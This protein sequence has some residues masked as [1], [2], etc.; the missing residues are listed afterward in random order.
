MFPGLTPADYYE[1]GKMCMHDDEPKNSETQML[2]AVMKWCRD[3][4]NIR[5]LYTLADGIMGKCGYVYQAFNFKYG[6]SFKT[7]IYMSDKG[8][9]IHPRTTRHLCVENGQ[10]NGEKIGNISELTI[11]FMK[12]KGINPDALRY[13]LSDA[14]DKLL[15]ENFDWNH[16]KVFWLTPDFMKTKGITKYDGLMF[17][18]MLPLTKRDK[19]LFK[20]SPMNWDQPYPKDKDLAWRKMVG[21]KQYEPCGMPEWDLTQVEYN[22]KNVNAHK[23]GAT[24]ASFL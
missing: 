24:L 21:P 9:K 2:S 22:S 7:A 5:L 1:I 16:R 10:F 11:E 18:Y 17:R 3:N 14:I 8:E 13:F 23:K 4:T 20:T 19:R 6:G 12:H 15:K